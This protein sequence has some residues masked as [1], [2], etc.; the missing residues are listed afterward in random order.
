MSE[1]ISKLDNSRLIAKFIV[2]GVETVN[3]RDYDCIHSFRKA[4]DR[5]RVEYETSRKE[6]VRR[7]FLPVVAIPYMDGAIV[8]TQYLTNA[9]NKEG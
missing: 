2:T 8:L 6:L 1:D 9:S 3:L 4:W 5:V 7:G